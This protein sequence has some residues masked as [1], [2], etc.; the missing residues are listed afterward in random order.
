MPNH[1]KATAAPSWLGHT[2]CLRSVG[3]L[4]TGI[5]IAHCPREPGRNPMIVILYPGASDTLTLRGTTVWRTLS[6]SIDVLRLRPDPLAGCGRHASSR[7]P[8]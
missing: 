2:F 5:E 7:A 8:C 1:A 6:R 4:P 3:E